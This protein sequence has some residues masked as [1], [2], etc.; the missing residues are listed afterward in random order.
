MALP[1][2]DK[3]LLCTLPVASL[4]DTRIPVGLPVTVV[5]PLTSAYT[6]AP[7]VL[8][9]LSL[10][11]MPAMVAPVTVTPSMVA[12]V[13]PALEPAL[14]YP[15]KLLTLIPRSTPVMVPPDTNGDVWQ[16]HTDTPVFGIEVIPDPLIMLPEAVDATVIEES[17]IPSHDAV[18]FTLATPVMV[19]PLNVNGDALLYARLWKIPRLRAAMLLPEMF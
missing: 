10:T 15:S 4:P 12:D 9:A 13:L 11:L 19:L 3:M 2:M 17:K 14:G 5:F 18:S 7:F 1:L 8:S 16:F 6:V